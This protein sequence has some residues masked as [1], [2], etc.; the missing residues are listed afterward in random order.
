MINLFLTNVS[1][2]DPLK[3]LE[4]QKISGVFRG[5]QIGVLVRNGFDV[6]LTYFT[7]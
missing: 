5:F 6:S 4:N 7:L 3:I 2:L 1:I